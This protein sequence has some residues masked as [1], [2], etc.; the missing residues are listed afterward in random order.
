[1]SPLYFLSDMKRKIEITSIWE[2]PDLFE[3][4]IIGSNG[5]F[6]GETNCYT[7]R[8]EFAKLG[9]LL[10]EFELKVGNEVKY[11]TF[12]SSEFSYF[13]IIV[14][15]I[16]ITG[17]IN[18]RTIIAHNLSISN[19]PNENYKVEF[20]FDI[21]PASLDRFAK[22]IQNVANSDLGKISA[23]LLAKI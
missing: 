6:S 9:K 12:H 14:R 13:T 17:L 5:K 10:D 18:V 3:I 23:I 22:E 20:D 8:E 19:A 1:M 11:S 4:Q 2:D 16:D 21:D 7:Q 15:C